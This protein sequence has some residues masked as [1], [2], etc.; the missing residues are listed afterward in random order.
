MSKERRKK[1]KKRNSTTGTIT[2]KTVL[3]ET[4]E[5]E[6]RPRQIFAII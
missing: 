3:S 6:K 4:S 5:I 1:Q 2:T